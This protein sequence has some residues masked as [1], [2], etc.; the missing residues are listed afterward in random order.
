MTLDKN[1][2]TFPEREVKRLVREALSANLITYSK[3]A[4]W[5]RGESKG[6]CRNE[7]ALMILQALVRRL[8]WP[9]QEGSLR[10]MLDLTLREAF[11][12]VMSWQEVK[13]RF[14]IKEYC[15]R[16]LGLGFKGGKAKCPLHDGHTQTSFVIDEIRNRWTCFGNCEPPAGQ[17]YSQG[18]VLD[19]HQR[20]NGF[21]DPS[22]ALCD[23]LGRR[24]LRH[25]T[26][27]FSPPPAQPK[28]EK[29]PVGGDFRHPGSIP[30]S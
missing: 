2:I 15:E 13:A 27:T 21:H 11:D 4:D 28:R 6:L 5:L 23:L 17:D 9:F 18:D 3:K 25:P 20:L 7:Q 30:P 12:S 24:P 8:N 26:L 14:P 16:Y 29:K 22:A 19:L 1:I 10:C